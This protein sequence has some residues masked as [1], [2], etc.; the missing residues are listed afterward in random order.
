M[1]FG[2]TKFLEKNQSSKETISTYNRIINDFFSVLDHE[3]TS[4]LEVFEIQTR[5]IKSY[6]KYIEKHRDMSIATINRNI[7]VLTKFFDYLW[8]SNQI[9]ID[10]MS[11]IRR[12]KEIKSTDSNLDYQSLV[13]LKHNIIENPNLDLFIKVIYVFALKGLTQSELKIKKENMHFIDDK[14]VITVLSETQYQSNMRTIMFEGEDIDIIYQLYLESIFQPTPYL[15]TRRLHLK[16]REGYEYAGQVKISTK[17]V[18]FREQ[19]PEFENYNLIETRKAY[20]LHLYQQLNYSINQI[21]YL[22]CR[23]PFAIANVINQYMT[24]I[25]YPQKKH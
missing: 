25:E 17:L 13:N 3:Q 22:M 4:E 8:E 24:T 19:Y 23:R 21:G 12:K 14:L 5:H 20:I 9:P 7:T 6:L 2:F 16:E 11:K 18:E 1:P 15:L 10:P